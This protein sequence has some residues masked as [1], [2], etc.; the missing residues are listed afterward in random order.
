MPFVEYKYEV[1]ERSRQETIF[2]KLPILCKNNEACS[3]NQP[4]IILS[5]L[6]IKPKLLRFY[7][8]NVQ[9]VKCELLE[10]YEHFNTN[11]WNNM[12]TMTKNNGQY[13]TGH[14][15]SSGL[16]SLLSIKR[17][18]NKYSTYS[19]HKIISATINCDRVCNFL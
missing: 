16:R 5:N 14:F 1:W 18:D 11:I 12:T 4:I 15:L 10:K 13:L 2:A 9:V 8:V 7:Y 19:L 17:K 3:Q 6:W